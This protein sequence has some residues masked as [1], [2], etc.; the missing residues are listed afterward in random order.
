MI[1]KLYSLK[2][3][4]EIILVSDVMLK[5]QKGMDFPYE[6][7]VQHSL[8]AHFETRDGGIGIFPK[9]VPF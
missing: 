6:G 1:R 3:V 4:I 2:N 8:E 9:S 5:Y 7:F